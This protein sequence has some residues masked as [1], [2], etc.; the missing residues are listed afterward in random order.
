[1]IY[2]LLKKGDLMAHFYHFTGK[3]KRGNYPDGMELATKDNI[4][5]ISTKN[6]VSHVNRYTF[7]T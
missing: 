4:D 2:L 1:V 7:N 6:F 5:S 3:H